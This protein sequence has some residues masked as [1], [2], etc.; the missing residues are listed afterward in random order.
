MKNEQELQAI[1]C[2]LILDIAPE[3]DIDT[4]DHDE[5]LRE[6]LDLDSID[7][8]NLLEAVSLETGVTI[9]EIDYQKVNSLR[10]MVSY[11]ASRH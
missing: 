1:V 8:M 5:D 11:I 9:S 3:A 4:L 7:F 2:R 10:S 6:E